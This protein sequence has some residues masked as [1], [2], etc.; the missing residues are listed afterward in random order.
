MVPLEKER[1]RDKASSY[2]IERPS[3]DIL[4]LEAASFTQ[5]LS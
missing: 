4:E 3:N 2:T 1:P 5:S